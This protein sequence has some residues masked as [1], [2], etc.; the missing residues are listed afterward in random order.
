MDLQKNGL[1]LSQ[2]RKEKGLTQEQ[3]GER[4]GVSN[5]TISRWETGTYLPPVEMLQ[6]LSRLY[7]LTINELLSG[8]TL[9][10]QEFQ[11][12]A[13]KNICSAL[14]STAITHKGKIRYYMRQWVVTHWLEMALFA[15][16]LV[17]GSVIWG[18]F[19]TDRT[20][21][22]AVL[23]AVGYGILCYHRMM[24]YAEEKIY[25]FA[26]SGPEQQVD[27]KMRHVRVAAMLI[28][29]LCLWISVDLGYNYFSALVPEMNDGLTIRG[30]F[31]RFV[32]GEDQWSLVKYFRAFAGVA[33]ITLIAA[34]TNIVLFCR[35]KLNI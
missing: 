28:F 31:A 7:G 29:G 13:E 2:L 17:V 30:L 4:L 12:S 14:E 15:V 3:L 22:S 33:K 34:I 24:A 25:T 32:I 9:S 21:P 27:R 6:E 18:C 26:E 35:E 10:E 19:S 23:I 1:F 11:E 16:L 5:K 20:L 8:K